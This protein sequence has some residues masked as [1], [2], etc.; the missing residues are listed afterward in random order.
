ML[1]FVR[2]A[3]AADR[4]DTLG[5]LFAG[6]LDLSAIPALAEL[7]HVGLCQP[8]RYLPP[9]AMDP[10]WVLTWLTLSTFM[11]SIDLDR[12]SVAVGDILAKCPQVTQERD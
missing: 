6:K 12:V 7:R 3:F 4:P 9:W 5:L 10:G 8:A 11:A 1:T 2:A